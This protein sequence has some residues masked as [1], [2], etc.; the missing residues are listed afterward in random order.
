[1]Q[2]SVLGIGVNM[3]EVTAALAQLPRIRYIHGSHPGPKVVAA[4]INKMMLRLEHVMPRGV[5]QN[6]VIN[7][8]K[9]SAPYFKS[10][11]ALLAGYFLHN[12]AFP[13][14]L[15]FL[16]DINLP[17]FNLL[18]R[19]RALNCDLHAERYI[20]AFASLMAKPR[21]FP[22]A[23]HK[24]TPLAP[25]FPFAPKISPRPTPP[26]LVL[27]ADASR[28]SILEWIAENP[29]SP[30]ANITP[31]TEVMIAYVAA[32]IFNLD[33]RQEG[34]PR[35]VVDTFAAY[36]VQRALLSPNFAYQLIQACTRHYHVDSYS[37]AR[38]I[39]FVGED[40]VFQGVD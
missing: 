38:V 7:Q 37:T 19:I 35:F 17:Y 33:A 30:P 31:F 1:M 4:Y 15:D 2:C 18:R 3:E 29:A 23:E 28:R 12:N 34:P 20:A 8:L 14:E 6:L 32:H 36:A 22:T 21:T 24:P 10:M 11:R 40:D 27:D 25:I 16:S 26:Q 39:Y 13:D 9:T 5:L